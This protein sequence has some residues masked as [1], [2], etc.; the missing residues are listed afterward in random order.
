M[1]S[2]KDANF[3]KFY[4][5][6]E[7]LTGDVHYR[8]EKKR[9]IQTFIKESYAKYIKE[10]NNEICPKNV[11]IYRQGIAYNQLKYVEEEVKLIRH[12]CNELHLNYYYVNVN[13]RVTTKLFEYNYIKDQN[14]NGIYKNPEQGLIILDQITNNNK[15]EFYIQPQKVN[16]GSATPT[17][18]HVP[19]GNMNFPEIL[20]Q[21]TYWTTYLY[22]NWQNAV[23]VPHVIKMAEKLAYMTAKFTLSEL[24]EKLS[25]DKQAFL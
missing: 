19:Y 12:V 22:S 25:E 15:F 17:Y 13:T 24:N 5:K 20:I 1:V 18:F 9:V 2:T 21:L 11:I 6:E 8:S 10:N 14:N 23:R 16:I 3:S 4:C 7:I